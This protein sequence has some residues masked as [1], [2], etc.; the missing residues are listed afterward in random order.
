MSILE[1]TIMA[2]GGRDRV[3]LK[4]FEDHALYFSKNSI[5]YLFEYK[6]YPILCKKWQMTNVLDC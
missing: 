3:S 2:G 6:K 1:Y 5:L 4:R